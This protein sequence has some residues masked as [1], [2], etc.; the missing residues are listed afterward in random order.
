MIIEKLQKKH[1]NGVLLLEKMCFSNPWSYEDLERQLELETSHFSVAVENGEVLGYMGLQIFSKEGYVTNIAVHPKYRRR[2]IAE[3]L[4]D[5]QLKNEMTFITLEVRESNFPAI[6]L[7]SKKGFAEIGKRP[8]FY[9]N[10]LEDALIMT[11]SL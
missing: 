6:E 10:P 1:L 5:F 4:I 3:A 2:G 8:D 7:Y 9:T 11:K